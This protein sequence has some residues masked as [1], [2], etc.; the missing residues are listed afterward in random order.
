MIEKGSDILYAASLLSKGGLVAFPTETVYGL[1][2]NAFDPVAVAR[3]FEVKQRPSFDPLIVH[4]SDIE[5]IE[6]LF[7]KP[8]NPLVYE[9]AKKFWPGPLTIVHTKNSHVPDIVTSGLST[10]AVR[11]P[12][13]PVALNL[14][15]AAKTPVAA[16]SANRFGRI[17]PTRP[18]HVIKQLSGIDYLLTGNAGSV[19]IESTVVSAHKGYCKLLRPGGISAHDIEQVCPCKLPNT[20]NFENSELPSPGLLT[21]HYA[22]NKPIY[23]VPKNQ[24]ANLPEGSGVILHSKKAFIDARRVVYTS[25][26]QNLTEVAANLFMA[27]H[28]MEDDNTIQQIYIEP[29]SETG[30]GIAIMDRVKKAAFKYK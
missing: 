9:L 27:M 6:L 13:H 19:G 22:P 15:R 23:I 12:L 14:I 3:I 8:I 29:V 28:I 26:N 24:L 10:V 18:S 2:A 5:Q 21:S 4:I 25:E 11:M 1:G 7:E 30:L 17:S 20:E 16:P